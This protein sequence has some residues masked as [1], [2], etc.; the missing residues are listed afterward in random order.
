M[1]NRQVPSYKIVELEKKRHKY[2]VCVFVINEGKRIQQQLERMKKYSFA[3]DII[4]ADGGS[5]DG[6]LT[7]NI[8]KKG[9]VRTLLIKTGAGKLSAQMRMA[10]D[11]A[12]K[13]NY[14]GVVVMDGNNKDTPDA[15]PQFVDL[16]ERGYDHIQ[17]SRYIRG[18][19]EKNT[20]ILRKLAVILLHAPLISIAAGF[21]YTDT[22]NGFRAYSAR[23]LNDKRVNPF[24]D[25][26][27]KYEL[28]YYLAI[29]ATELKYKV[30]ETPVERV[31][32]NKGKTPTKIH[33]WRGYTDIL[34]TMLKACLH[35]YNP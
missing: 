19:V 7:T 2:C 8:L 26:F 31:Y 3:I 10:F 21:R 18:G 14:R 25:I 13:N 12:L 28:H 16:L 20:P 5:T 17:G 15:L 9:N 30:T 24:R 1:R 23:F 4:V 6:S 22:T 29:R 34:L 27:S 33:S 35:K 11:Y 32:P